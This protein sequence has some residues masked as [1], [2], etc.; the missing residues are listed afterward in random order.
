MPNYHFFSK[1]HQ[2]LAVF[3]ENAKSPFFGQI[4]SEMPFGM[5][6]QMKLPFGMQCQMPNEIAI[7]QITIF[8]PN[9]VWNAIWHAMPNEIAIWHAMPN[10][11]WNCHLACNAKW[12]YQITIFFPNC[13][14]NAIWHANGMKCQ[15][16]LPFGMQCQMPN[17]ITIWHALPKL[18]NDNGCFGPKC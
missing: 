14:W 7:W 18:P 12:N 4:P 1:F 8:L 13:V 11:K 6:C 5:Q 17:D 9:C 2:K 3:A 16:K 15:M 10:A